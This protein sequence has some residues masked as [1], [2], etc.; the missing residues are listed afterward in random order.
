MVSVKFYCA[1]G[2]K[3][4]CNKTMRS[5]SMWVETTAAAAAVA[6]IAKYSSRF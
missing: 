3:Q 2:V 6:A 5:A 1:I 4:L